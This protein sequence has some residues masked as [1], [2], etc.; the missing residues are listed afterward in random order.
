M[1]R[2]L[3]TLTTDFGVGDNYVAAVKG[4]ILTICPDAQIVDITHLVAPQDIEHGVYLT[5]TA[6]P[7]FPQGT[8]HVA[9]VDPGVGTDRRPL[10]LATPEASFIGPDNGVLSAVLPPHAR[11]TTARRVAVPEGLRALVLDNKR[12][13]RALPSHTFHA[14]DIFGPVAAH[15]AAGADT[16]A[17]GSSASEIVALPLT[18]AESDG[19]TVR[20]KVLHVDTFGNLVSNIPR[21]MIDV[22]RVTVELAGATVPGLGRTYGEHDELFAL[23]TS[24]GWLA[25]AQPNGS[26]ASMLGVTRGEPLLVRLG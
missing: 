16:Q 12:F 11:P 24:D 22:E 7:Y 5:S 2:P 21:A 1:N 3:I 25:V 19:S 14:R 8:I 9:V 13:Y 4:A 20:G 17:I 18:T 15:L 23:L 6:W 10:F 26:A